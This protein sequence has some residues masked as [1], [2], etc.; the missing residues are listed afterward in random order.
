MNHKKRFH[1][2]MLPLQGRGDLGNGLITKIFA[3]RQPLKDITAI[4]FE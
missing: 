3:V 2:K 4:V 1:C